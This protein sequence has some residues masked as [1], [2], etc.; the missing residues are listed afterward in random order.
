MWE[1]PTAVTE[2]CVSNVQ[3]YSLHDGGGIRT[4][5]FLKGCPF[6]CP[7]CCN[8][9]GIGFEPEVSYSEKLCIHCSPEGTD[10]RCDAPPDA[11][12]TGAKSV[13]GE[14]RAVSSLV[15]EALRDATF[16]EESG[17]GVTV[18]GGECLSGPSRQAFV[19]NLLSG[20]KDHGT[21]TALE[22][23]LA[24]PLA[25]PASLVVVT[26]EFL[27]DLKVS[28]RQRSLD[29]CG[30]DPEVRDSNLE[31]IMGL[32]AHVV[33]RLPIIPGFTDGREVVA[34]NIATML[35]LGIG[36]A[37]ILPFHQLGEA[38]YVSTGRE[39]ACRDLPQLG[40]RDVAW[41]VAACEEAGVRAVTHG[42]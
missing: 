33:A 38:K 24:V 21:S 35:R 36:R 2:E 40:E 14:M 17:G 16:F 37:D 18:S 25:D 8:P 23:T 32:G 15:D 41:V 31:S 28:D 4:V 42:E 26:D 20:C 19:T 6:H 27:V 5:V 13:I 9:E 7:W 12:P 1:G 34:A 39:Y 3:R 22:T 10:G 30:I 29:V 11:C